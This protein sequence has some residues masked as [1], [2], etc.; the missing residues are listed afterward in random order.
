MTKQNPWFVRLQPK[1]N[2]NFRLFC[3]PYAGGGSYIYTDWVHDF[4]PD[5]ELIAVQPPGRGRR[6]A[7]PAFV[8]ID[9]LIQNLSQTLLD[10]FN[11]GI[12]FA[13]FG[14]S[15]GALVA[16]E[17]TQTLRQQGNPQPHMLFVSGHR[18]PHVPDRYP[19]VHK[20]PKETFINKLRD[21][22]GTPQEILDNNEFLELF[23]PTLRADFTLCETYS[24][25]ERDPLHCP[26]FAFGGISD[27]Q[28]T[29]EDINAW[30]AHTTN[31]FRMRMFVGD[32]FFLREAQS[33]LTALIRAALQHKT[34]K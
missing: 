12:P 4:P 26:I 30:Q 7:E 16:Y 19:P 17:L 3:F 5:I 31:T 1:P 33:T 14:H 32:H 11:D 28:I 25:Q 6:F 22:N 18:A 29:T 21:Y 9:A 34:T 20:M 27:P 8:R 23:L 15:M 10:N 13:F 2:A 24:Y